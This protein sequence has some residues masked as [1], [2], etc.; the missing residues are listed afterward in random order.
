[1]DYSWYSIHPFQW[2]IN[3][4]V[5]EYIN[6]PFLEIIIFNAVFCFVVSFI[7]IGARVYEFFIKW[8]GS[9]SSRFIIELTNESIQ[10]RRRSVSVS[11]SYPHYVIYEKKEEEEEAKTIFLRSQ[12][13]SH[14]F[15][16][17]DFFRCDIKLT[18]SIVRKCSKQT[19]ICGN[20][21]NALIFSWQTLSVDCM[22]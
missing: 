12:A 15:I 16:W 13:H 9:F 1:M 2:C 8:H 14:R 10:A 11:S 17:S 18:A 5:I 22:D 7:F 4:G 21:A 6:I 3:S 20:F 19:W